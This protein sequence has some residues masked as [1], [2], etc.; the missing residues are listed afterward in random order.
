MKLTATS[1]KNP[2]AVAVAV[3]IIIL[4]GLFTLNK[5]PVQLFPDIERPQISIATFWRAASPKEIE[6]EILEPQEEVLQGLPG[7]TSMNAFANAGASFINLE[8]SLDTDMDKMLVEVISRINRV[9]FLPAD[10]NPPV[11]SLGG[12]GFGGSGQGLTWFFV[13]LLPGTEGEVLDYERLVE[14]IVKPK[15]ES[16]N[17]VSS[18]QLFASFGNPEELQIIFD[19]YKA[20]N[21][22]VNIPAVAA[23]AGRA[24]DVS[25]G[26]KDVGRRRYTLRFAGRYTPEQLGNLI[27][28]N[29]D[30]KV[31]RLSDVAEIKVG[32]SQRAGV[33]IQNGN[34]AMSLRVDK[35]SGANA[36]DTLI[37]VK[38]VVE[39]IRPELESHGLTIAQSFD[40]SVFIN[41][42]INLVTSNLVIGVLLAVGILWWFLRRLR[43]TLIVALAIPV[44]LFATFVV[45]G[46]TGRSLNV[47]SLAGL[48]FAVGMVL[49][50]AIVVLENIVRLRTRGTA[51]LEAAEKGATQV[52]GALIASTATTVAIFLPVIFLQDVEGQ[53]FSDLALTI[54]IAVTISLF[55]AVTVLPVAAHLW[56]PNEGLKDPHASTWHK[57][58]NGIMTITNSKAKRTGWIVGLIAVPAIITYSLIPSL[59][60]L[61][62]VKRDAVD[63]FFNLPPGATVETIEKDIANVIR[64]RLQPYMDGEKQPELKNYYLF[65]GN[66]G[67]NFGVRVKDQSRVK[68]MEKII[69]EEIAVGLPDVRVFAQQG[70]LFGGFGGGRSIVVNMQSKDQEALMQAARDGQN[71]FSELIPGM[72]AQ[73]FPNPEMAEPELRLIP[74]DRRLTEVGWNRNAIGQIVRSLGNGVYIGEHFNGERRM[75]IIL[76]AEGWDTPEELASIPLATPS[77]EV[78]SLGELVTLERT[79]GPSNMRRVDRRR[80]M[81]FNVN[82]PD[83]MS[84][85]EAI[86]AIEQKV[87]PELKK[88]LPPDGSIRY[89]GS[90]DSLKAAIS[91]MSENFVLALL[92]LFMLM[93]ALFRSMKDS[94]LVVIAIPLA[95][96]GGV[97]AL[98]VMNFFVFQPLDLLTMIGFIILL[99]LVVNNAI[100]L[101][102]Q[103]RDAERNGMPRTDA[104]R[105]ALSIR[106]RPIFMSTL[107]SIFGMLPLLLLPGE[108]SVIYRGLAVVI[109]GGMCV[110]TIFTL[111]LLPSLLQLGEAPVKKTENSEQPDND[112]N[113]M[114]R[115][116]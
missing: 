83:G 51:P 70:K 25:G 80:T 79:V 27:L 53:L 2:A 96:V 56:V 28:D 22:G 44:S 99:G 109:V 5:L 1:L 65:A 76:R 112:S 46:L 20:A 64:D 88:L 78:V 69:N 62:P 19:P 92:I 30:G 17:G 104:V 35:E 105:Q 10:A 66:F 50:A 110:S 82:P 97:L 60:Y 72:T 11:I 86:A 7:M 45:L 95:T 54:A 94:A 55:V 3:A 32:H 24:N 106:M 93:S 107:T 100:L 71:L 14:D 108:G 41:R 16:V 21:L 111:L 26:F 74:D 101:V 13:Q 40:A 113:D 49:D 23:M 39:S 102:H 52:W 77:G 116:A 8:F 4:F 37:E 67:G 43:A 61:P 36:L 59:D 114:V 38:K 89:A 84:L 75:N 73:P 90:A 29:R 33:S 18:V 57:L 87:E 98:R 34:P 48:A 115:V 15:I 85:Q 31:I 9:P 12:G 81:S 91:T 42:A 58:S 6:S 63:G 47:I 68:E 103:T